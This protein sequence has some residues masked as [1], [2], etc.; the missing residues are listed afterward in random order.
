MRLVPTNGFL[1]QCAGDEQEEANH[2]QLG[3][4]AADVPRMAVGLTSDGQVVDPHVEVRPVHA[5]EEGGAQQGSPAAVPSNQQTQA[6]ANFHD[7]GQ[8]YPEGGVAEHVG[9]DG[10]EPGGVRE[11]LDANEDEG[12]P[13]QDRH[14]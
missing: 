8:P 1:V 3:D 10:F 5:Y 11:V 7:T 12:P 9:D 4:Q 14:K 2:A 6:E 13:I